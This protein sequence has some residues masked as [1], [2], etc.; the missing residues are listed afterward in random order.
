[1]VQRG[2]DNK[3]HHHHQLTLNHQAVGDP[4]RPLQARMPHQTVQSLPVHAAQRVQG[5][6]AGHGPAL[7]GAV[8]GL[9][10]QVGVPGQ[11][12][13]R[14]AH[15]PTGGSHAEGVALHQGDGLQ[16]GDG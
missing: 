12:G 13:Q 15:G 11:T 16:G 1:M 2:P 14:A 7:A 5:E 8:L 4:S 3:K 10:R 9:A 6:V